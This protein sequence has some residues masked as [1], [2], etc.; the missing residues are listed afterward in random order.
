MPTAYQSASRVQCAAAAVAKLWKV[1]I[2]STTGSLWPRAPQW[3][4]CSLLAVGPQGA[5]V[6]TEISQ[7]G[8]PFVCSPAVRVIGSWALLATTACGVGQGSRAPT[9]D[10]SPVTAMPAPTISPTGT[11]GAADAGSPAEADASAPARHCARMPEYPPLA[12][13]QRFRSAGRFTSLVPQFTAPEAP[14][15]A[16]VRELQAAVDATVVRCKDCESEKIECYVVRNDGTD[17]GI[18]CHSEHSLANHVRTYGRDWGLSFRREGESFRRASLADVAREGDA[19]RLGQAFPLLEV[20]S[21]AFFLLGDDQLVV[22][23]QSPLEMDPD[24]SVASSSELGEALR[25]DEVLW[26]RPGA[27][28]G[29][30]AF[31]FRFDPLRGPSRSSPRFR[32]LGATKAAVASALEQDVQGWVSRAGEWAPDCEVTFSDDSIVSV[33]CSS[34]VASAGFSYRL[35]DGSRVRVEELLA[36]LPAQRGV[37]TRRCFDAQWTPRPVTNLPVPPESGLSA[38]SLELDAVVFALPYVAS[39]LD[40][41]VERLALCRVSYRDLH[42]TLAEIAR[43]P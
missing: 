16:T 20:S 22:A 5:L 9:R 35:E 30:L 14:L 13:A 42:T 38:F 7:E 40:P 18:L 41:G 2:R 28:A 25:C 23:A 8:F 19:R 36:R 3:I 17:L 12:V 32:A 10:P 27:A 29:P 33:R 4:R 24:W 37:L 26:T 6:L 31:S 21:D 39:D 11:D 43:G 34:L 15:A 1:L